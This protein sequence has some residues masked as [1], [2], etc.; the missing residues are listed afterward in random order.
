MHFIA[1][2]L[3]AGLSAAVGSPA[4]AADV[5]REPQRICN[6]LAE[7]GLPTHAW[8]LVSEIVDHQQYR[9]FRCI[10]EPVPV[11]GARG[12]ARSMTTLSF[13]AE[14]RFAERV[15][16]VK[17]VLNVHDEATRELGKKQLNE[18]ASALFQRLGLDQPAELAEAIE[19]ARPGSFRQSY[20][21]VTFESW[22]MPVERLRITLKARS[23]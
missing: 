3:L 7:R 2:L 5:F 22:R 19:E 12:A 18:L 15:E 1:I 9:T 20:G 17:L 14:G 23:R 13:F 4:E 8:K 16:Q 21:S 10:A 11:G 6:A